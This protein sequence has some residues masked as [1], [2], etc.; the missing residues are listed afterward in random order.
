MTSS[1]SNNA[2]KEEKDER[3]LNFILITMSALFIGCQSLKI[4]PDLY[5]LLVC[6]LT[7]HYCKMDGVVSIS[8][9]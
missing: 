3:N 7:G 9:I 4:V 8:L 1:S 2:N 5:E 6:K